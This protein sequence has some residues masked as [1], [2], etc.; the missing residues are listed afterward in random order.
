MKQSV[1]YIQKKSF[2]N[3]RISSSETADHIPAITNQNKLTNKQI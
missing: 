1:N 2:H 3:K